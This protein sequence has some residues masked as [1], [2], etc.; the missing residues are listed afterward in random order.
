[1]LKENAM[2]RMPGPRSTPMLALA[3]ACGLLLGG[4][5]LAQDATPIPVVTAPAGALS[6][7]TV[8]GGLP[9]FS[10]ATPSSASPDPASTEASQPSSGEPLVP[11][12]APAPRV[13]LVA[14][15]GCPNQVQASYSAAQITCGQLASGDSCLGSGVVEASPQEGLELAFAQP[16]DRAALANLTE[17]RLRTL[18]TSQKTLALVIGRPLFPTTSG[19]TAEATLI[20]V[21]DVTLVDDG[22][23]R[24]NPSAEGAVGTIIADFGLNVRRKPDP[25]AEV[26]WQLRPGDLINITGQTADKAW[27]RMEI[28]NQFSATAWVYAPYVEVVGDVPIVDPA[29]LPPRSAPQPSSSTTTTLFQPM[30]A[31]SLLS[32]TISADCVGAPPSGALIQTPNGLFDRMRLRVNDVL[33]DLSGTIFL[34]AQANDNLL[35]SVLEGEV[36]VTAQGAVSSA[37]SGF[38]VSVALGGNLEPLGP[39]LPD[40]FDQRELIGLPVS[41]LPRM[42]ELSL[43]QQESAQAAAPAVDT[44]QATAATTDS[45]FT[46]PTPEAAAPAVGSLASPESGELCGAAEF[47]LSGTSNGLGPAVEVGGVWNATAGTTISISASGGTFQPVL[48]DYIRITSTQGILARSAQE[49]SLTYT[50]SA[51]T[52]FTLGISAAASDTVTVRVRCGA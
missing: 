35:I 42:I 27:L 26:V 6:V 20:L 14:A 12:N 33:I 41:Q 11:T 46:A 22:D 31:F 21:G 29:S 43:V 13:P 30:Q 37:P 2:S 34:Q 40:S 38:R 3:L 47:T 45:G 5:A 4:T 8:P 1:M 15:G 50:F 25:S 49:Q 9:A 16:G 51:D 39:P 7:P 32:G 23:Q 36:N 10:S 18:D 24:P 17:L 28:P 48:G 44:P 19:S 52:A